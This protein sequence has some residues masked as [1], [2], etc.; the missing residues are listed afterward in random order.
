MW[1]FL[2]QGKQKYLLDNIA[3]AKYYLPTIYN[4]VEFY[5]SSLNELKKKTQ[6]K[7]TPQTS[8]KFRGNC[9]FLHELVNNLHKVKCELSHPPNCHPPTFTS[10]LK[11]TLAKFLSLI[12]SFKGQFLADNSTNCCIFP[13]MMPGNRNKRDSFLYDIIVSTKIQE[14]RNQSISKGKQKIV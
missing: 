14:S 3:K 1:S 11:Y 12:V 7:Q 10:T 9:Y 4:P 5:N 8:T 2:E 13:Y 6:K